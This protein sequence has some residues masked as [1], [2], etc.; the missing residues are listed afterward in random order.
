MCK[1]LP[2]KMKLVAL[3]SF[4]GVSNFMLLIWSLNYIPI[5]LSVIVMNISP[6]WTSILSK[7]FLNEPILNLE[8]VAMAI[9]FACVVG[10]TLGKDKTPDQEAAESTSSK[11]LMVGIIIMFVASWANAGMNICNREL[12]DVHFTFIMAWH[13]VLG[14]VAPLIVIIIWAITT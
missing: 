14:F 5:A 9:C 4:F 10:L 3:R 2:N 6:F 13:G 11:N 7:I 1:N 8:Y 12:K